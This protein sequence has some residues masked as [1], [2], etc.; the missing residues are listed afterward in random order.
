MPRAR[1]ERESGRRCSAP[2]SGS[3]TSADGRLSAFVVPSEASTSARQPAGV[4][5][6]SER[7]SSGTTQGTS[8]L[9]TRMPPGSTPSRPACTAAPWPPPG[10][11][12]VSAP[13]S[14]AIAAALASVVTT[15]VPPTDDAGRE[16]VAE[17]R[18]RQRPAYATR[19]MQAR[20]P[21]GRE[22]DHD[23]RHGGDTRYSGRDHR[24]DAALPRARL[25][26]AARRGAARGVA[27]G[28]AAPRRGRPARSRGRSRRG[29]ACA[30]A[31]SPPRCELRR[32]L[33]QRRRRRLPRA[34]SRGDEHARRSRRRSRRSHARA[35]PCLPAAR[36]HSG[37]VRPRRA[38]AARLGEAGAD[39]PRSRRLDAR[40]GGLRPDRHA[41]R[42]ACRGFRDAR[43]LQPTAAAGCRSTSYSPR[44]TS[45]HSMC[46]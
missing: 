37:S 29:R 33:R 26:R 22:R 28:R 32:R 41:G 42:E 4:A 31:R 40:A 7:R 13:A 6:R 3:K 39:G 38:M 10:S 24:G 20:L 30:P 36:R 5:A 19:A 43:R 16:H 2:Y 21:V 34:R 46:R 18:L 1:R 12:T 17:H 23:R 8:A 25:G 14:R 44:A 15:R 35:D 9:T 27:A 45:S 11:A